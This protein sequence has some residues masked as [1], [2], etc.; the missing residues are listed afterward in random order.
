MTVA[1]TKAARMSLAAR[2]FVATIHAYQRWISPLFA[3]RCR[4]HP[5]CSAYAA[6]AIASHGAIRGSW[7]AVR[8]LARCH[9]WSAGGIDEVPVSPAR[10]PEASP[11][12]EA[13]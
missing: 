2:I 10:S 13:L 12:A 6:V 7:L 3:A 9:P 1:A 5:T 11:P 4:F 8:R